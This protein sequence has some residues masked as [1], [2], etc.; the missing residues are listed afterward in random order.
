MGT[1]ICRDCG[2]PAI[3]DVDCWRCPQTNRPIK[4]IRRG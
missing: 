2:Q 3:Y 4:V 1:P